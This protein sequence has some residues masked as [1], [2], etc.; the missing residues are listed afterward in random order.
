MRIRFL[1]GAKLLEV[2]SRGIFILFCT[3]SLPIVDAGKF[4]LL[5]TVAGLAAFLLGF[6]RVIDV[7]RRVAGNASSVI[8]QRLRD[9]LHFFGVQYALAL[10]V[11]ALLLGLVTGWPLQLL[12]LFILIIVGEHLSNQ[13]YQ[14]TLVDRHAYSF[15]LAV[16]VKNVILLA[17]V[18]Y[19]AWRTPAHF[20]VVT[21]MHAWGW[22]SLGFIAVA[23][24]LWQRKS[25]RAAV[26][27]AD[28]LPRQRIAE[29]YRA[30]GL[31][32]LMGLVAIVALQADRFVVG[33]T[34]SPEDLG[35]YFRN[36]TLA[37]LALQFFNIV[38]FNRVAPNIYQ[39]AR[40]GLLERA[41]TVVKIEY[42]RFALTFACLV[43]L[44]LGLNLA[45]GNPAS[46]FH[47]LAPF[48]LILTATI[49]L[50]TLADYFG[51]LLLSIGEDA[52]L[53]RQQTA[54][55]AIGIPCMALMA[56]FHGLPGAFLGTLATPAVLLLLNLDLVRKRFQTAGNT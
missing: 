3:Y 50:R 41:R 27:T 35:I 46:R 34:L 28:A 51:L 52:I 19:I 7:Q 42:G 33:A 1:V 40:E 16:V 24:V 10:P 56:A 36:I 26:D 23:T 22:A 8:H 4:G 45:L 49:L 9:T 6:E 25:S 30:S 43:A 54:S 32:F 15:L 53:F 31:H 47:I 14:I 13:A 17:A 18:L 29:Q 39:L 48:A 21:V 37:G 44:A 2:L 12:A 38:S 20:D 5:S 55:I 11:M